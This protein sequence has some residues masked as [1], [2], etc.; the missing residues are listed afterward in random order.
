[1]KE[2]SCKNKRQ[3]SRTLRLLAGGVLFSLF[4]GLCACG[5]EAEPKKELTPTGIL[6]PTAVFQEVRPDIQGMQEGFYCWIGD[7]VYYAEW[8]MPEGANFP[9][10]TIYREALYGS[11]EREAVD[12]QDARLIYALFSDGAGNLGFIAA[13]HADAE[14]EYFLIREDENGQEISRVPLELP[15]DPTGIL[16]GA[17][18]P[19][20]NA[21]YVTSSGKA[22][23]LDQEGNSLGMA[24]L[25][26]SQP[27][28]LSCG[29]KGLYVYQA[30]L[31]GRGLMPLRKVDFAAGTVR[32][33]KDI[34][35]EGLWMEE[36]NINALGTEEGILLSGGKTLWQ[37]D[38]ETGEREEVFS[39]MAPEVNIDGSSVTAI[40]YGDAAEDGS[41][42]MEVL[43]AGWSAAVPEVARITYI[44]QAYVSE[45][46]TL[47]VGVSEY[48]M[49]EDAVR[50]FNRGN[51][52]YRVELKQYDTDTM[53][54]DLLTAPE[55]MPDILDISWIVPD[56]LAGKGLLENLEPYYKKSEIVKKDDILPAV[57][58]AGRIDGK[59]VG[60]VTSFGLQTYWTTVSDFPR[61]GW[62][63]EDFMA[64]VQQYPDKKPLST[65][66]PTTVMNLFS[67]TLLDD[68]VNWEKGKCTFDSPEFVEL[69]EQIASLDYPKE[70]NGGKKV[71]YEDEIVRNFLK[72]EYLLKSD[73]YAAPYYYI[74]A[75]GQYGDKAFN[76]GYPSDGDE[77]MFLMNINQQ[78]AIYS[79]SECK[80]GAWAF[81]EFLLSKEEQTWYGEVRSG[82]PVRKDAFAAYLSRPYSENR[83]F[84]GDDPGAGAEELAYMAEHMCKGDTIRLSEIWNI[85]WEEVPYLFEGDKDAA[86]VAELIQ[87][88]A[89]MYLK[90]K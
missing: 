25:G 9:R 33:Q 27:G 16:G 81:I 7:F 80:D 46:E 35:V 62:S 32:E 64:L 34:N 2:Q 66:S 47:V 15:E 12:V 59:E 71:Y 22:Y 86:T 14:R 60:A 84:A 43:L 54:S 19:A 4:L 49:L 11:G 72:Q 48:S 73:Y 57:W 41:R 83:D 30:D 44:D 38:P 55:E 85:I 3:K 56:V 69:L 6:V 89:N 63:L 23:L 67:A 58:E 79:N 13:E 28:I 29:E 70:E 42:E 88:R 21:V 61:D 74:Q 24:N 20:G 1:M 78:L 17:M 53:L 5:K 90:E 75:V 26:M 45:R 51:T 50:R 8:E 10:Y 77:P 36:L 18:D 39:W 40:R 37:Y 65:Y 31:S 52:G 76:I 68:F 87:N 82:F